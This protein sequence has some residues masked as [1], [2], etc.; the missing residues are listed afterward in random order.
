MISLAIGI[1]WLA[2]GII[3]VGGCI[4]LAFWGIRQLVPIAPPIEKIVW[5]VFGILC[6]IY[7]LVLL[8]GGGGLPHP[9]LFQR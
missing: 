7:V 1:L 6:L 8:E 4:M 2:I 3:V 9:A 5:A